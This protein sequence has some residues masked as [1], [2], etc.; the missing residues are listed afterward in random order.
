[1][2][3]SQTL[4]L[5]L[6][7]QRPVHP[8]FNE[9][10]GSQ[11]Q[12]VPNITWRPDPSCPPASRPSRQHARPPV[13]TP[14]PGQPGCWHAIL[15]LGGIRAKDGWAASALRLTAGIRN[16]RRIAPA[17]GQAAPRRFTPL[18]LPIRHSPCRSSARQ[19]P[20]NEQLLPTSP[21]PYLQIENASL[22]HLAV[23]A[24]HARVVFDLG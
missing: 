5:V 18:R 7:R 13:H 19:P 22:Q 1:M 14:W 17:S 9:L 12:S 20:D 10:L 11:I 16:S 8:V 6:H 24:H 4:R 3:Q 2:G 21:V 15:I 23:L